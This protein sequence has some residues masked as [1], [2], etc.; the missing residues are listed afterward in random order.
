[1]LHETYFSI[2]SWPDLHCIRKGMKRVWEWQ[3][4]V[5]LDGGKIEHTE[6]IHWAFWLKG[7]LHSFVP[8]GV[9]MAV[10]LHQCKWI[11]GW[12]TPWGLPKSFSGWPLR[13]V[14][15]DLWL[16]WWEYLG[17][18]QNAV[19]SLRDGSNKTLLFPIITHPHEPITVHSTSTA[20]VWEV[21]TKKEKEEMIYGCDIWRCCC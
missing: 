16:E 18:E 10:L 17:A 6:S 13:M 5:K 8:T 20:G 21:R 12:S 7:L 3:I 1:M 9:C 4:V 19:H 14:G 11:S 2:E 15:L